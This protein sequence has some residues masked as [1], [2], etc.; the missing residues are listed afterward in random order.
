MTSPETPAAAQ[1]L[2]PIDRLEREME[3]MRAAAAETAE[4]VKRLSESLMHEQACRRK[5]ADETTAL[6]QALADCTE[7]LSRVL[8]RS[9]RAVDETTALQRALAECQEQLRQANDRARTAEDEVIQLQVRLR[10]VEDRHTPESLVPPTQTTYAAAAT[11]QNSDV[12]ES[13]FTTTSRTIHL[14]NS[15]ARILS[16]VPFLYGSTALTTEKAI[17]ESLLQSITATDPSFV[18]HIT[19]IRVLPSKKVIV[20]LSSPEQRYLWCAA[21]WDHL[22]Q[23]AKIAVP[24]ISPKLVLHQVPAYMTTSEIAEATGASRAIKTITTVDESDCVGKTCAFILELPSW[25]Q[26]ES[27][28]RQGRIYYQHCAFPVSAYRTRERPP[29][30]YRCW[31]KGHVQARCSSATPICGQCAE[32][33]LTRECPLSAEQ[34]RKCTNCIAKGIPAD[35]PAW[36][37]NCRSHIMSNP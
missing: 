23:G 2:S 9:Q 11:A 27:L 36:A 8:D 14:Q 6:K 32:P 15:Q 3:L 12:H 24:R 31:S 17:R 10:A 5:A 28:L 37:R 35:H 18:N 16:Q 26:V 30:C 20:Q 22:A 13:R 1:P 21:T 34:P 4:T 19:T 25:D 33:H 7:Q 29:L